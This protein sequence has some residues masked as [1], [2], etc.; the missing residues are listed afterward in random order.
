MVYILPD[1]LVSNVLSLYS[2]FFYL[3]FIS[4]INEIRKIFKN[5]IKTPNWLGYEDLKKLQQMYSYLNNKRYISR[6]EDKT[7]RNRAIEIL[8][9]IKMK[10]RKGVKF[11]ELGCGSGLVCYYLN[12]YGQAI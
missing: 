6:N 2:K 9:L 10:S 8:K 7:G 4:R 1:H 12:L 11:L 5:S 3:L